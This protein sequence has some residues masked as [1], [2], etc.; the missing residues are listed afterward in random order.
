MNKKT[1][2]LIFNI[3]I[4]ILEIIATILSYKVN[5]RVLIEYYTI[6]SNL[7]I[8]VTSLIYIIF[9][10]MKK[11]IP[12]WLSMLKYIAT[13]CLV[14]TFVIVMLILIP[15]A[16][17]NFKAMLID[18]AMLYHHL[19]CPILALITFVFFDDLGTYNRKDN[20]IGILIT[21]IYA[22]VLIILNIVNVV[23]GPYP[24]LMVRDQS[25]LA[26]TA[27][28][29]GIFVIEYMI[30]LGVRIFQGKFNKATK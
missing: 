17:F 28:F 23:S 8:M 9:I 7:L 24:F 27:W 12:R 20:I 21:Q 22:A 6:D 3:A 26:S 1:L 2:S 13:T 11:D 30:A 4:I 19:L 25:I 14:I 5:S 16:D 18:D 29:I 10:F 15:M